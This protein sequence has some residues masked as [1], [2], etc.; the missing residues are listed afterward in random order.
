MIKFSIITITYNAE[1]VLERTLESVAAQTYPEIEHI[2]VDGASKDG[3]LTIAEEYRRQSDAARNGHHVLI[4]SEPDKGI[5][6]AMNKGLDYAMGT[7]IVFMNAGDSFASPSTITDIA[8][9]T[10]LNVI[11]KEGR[12]LPAVVYGDTDIYDADGNYLC[13]RH[14]SAPERLSWRSFRNGMLVCHQAFYAR[15]DIAKSFKYS[16]KYRYSADVDWC[17][18]VMKAAERS[19]LSMDNVHQVVA[20]YLQEG[21]TT[22]HRRASLKERFAIMCRHYGMFSTLIMHLLF[23]FRALKRKFFG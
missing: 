4:K 16:L 17:I 13:H 21:Q 2:I 19:A 23:V 18:R 3:T 7:Y 6:D 20:H 10:S 5:Y 8:E 14:L 11:E 22:M 1:A 15:T 12:P 9:K